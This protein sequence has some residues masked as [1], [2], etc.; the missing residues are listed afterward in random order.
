M[1]LGRPAKYSPNYLLPNM[2]EARVL[3]DPDDRN[4]CVCTVA[5][6]NARRGCVVVLEEF[7][8]QDEAR[9]YRDAMRY[10][11]CNKPDHQDQ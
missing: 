2:Q 7:D 9:A 11:W 3:H 10:A 6:I 8:T 1:I 4:W 5:S